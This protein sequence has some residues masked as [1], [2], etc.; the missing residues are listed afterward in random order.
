VKIAVFRKGRASL[1]LIRAAAHL[2]R[3]AGGSNKFQINLTVTR[4]NE[5]GTV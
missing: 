4:D 2:K 3:S 5:L 1:T